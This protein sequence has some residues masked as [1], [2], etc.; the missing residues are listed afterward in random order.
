M[1]TPGRAG[2]VGREISVTVEGVYKGPL[3]PPAMLADYEAALPGAAERI[4][5]MAERR[6]AAEIDLDHAAIAAAQADQSNARLGLHYGAMVSLS[7]I[8]A[9]VTCVVVGAAYDAE[10]AFYVA[11]IFAGAGFFG[12][13]RELIR[14]RRSERRDA[15][16]EDEADPPAKPP[17]AD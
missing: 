16:S 6:Q 9:A 12:I 2:E 8:L 5:A 17:A 1:G 13:V 14:G 11:G 7:M 4:L 3:P 10:P 15:Q